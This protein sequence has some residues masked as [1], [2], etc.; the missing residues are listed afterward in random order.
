MVEEV[1]N[2]VSKFISGELINFDRSFRAYKIGSYSVNPV[3]FE[4]LFSR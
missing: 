2:I 1:Y 3:H 4:L